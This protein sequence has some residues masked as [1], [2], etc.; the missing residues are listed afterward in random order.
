MK[1]C[2]KFFLKRLQGIANITFATAIFITLLG[3]VSAKAEDFSAG[4]AYF[5]LSGMA[6]YADGATIS[7][8]SGTTNPAFDFPDPLL[9]T[10]LGFG[11]VGAVGWLTD[12]N[13][14]MEFELGHR[15][16]ALESIASPGRAT[17]DGD[18]SITT[19]FVNVIRISVT[20]PSSPL[21]QG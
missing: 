1:H 2:S 7:S 10:K 21:M 12:T 20:N 8:A 19:A 14:R 9:Q 18:L 17:L 16:V 13:W 6:A 3:T 11:V 5:S 4:Q 15:E